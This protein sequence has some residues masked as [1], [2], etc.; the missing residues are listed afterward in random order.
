MNNGLRCFT[1]VEPS[2]L[3]HFLRSLGRGVGVGEGRA[4]GEGQGRSKLVGTFDYRVD[5]KKQPKIKEG[6]VSKS[7]WRPTYVSTW[8][9]GTFPVRLSR[10]EL[11]FA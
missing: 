5:G 6:Q 2:V 8:V 7:V 11:V 10:F 3:K 1:R 4:A 9:G